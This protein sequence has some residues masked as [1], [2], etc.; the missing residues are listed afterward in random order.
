MKGKSKHLTEFRVR[1]Y[2]LDSYGHMNNAVY[3][4]YLEQARWEFT[5]DVS[6]LNDFSASDLFL[7]VVETH[8]RYL[9][10]AR[11]FDYLTV[12]TSCQVS[13][14]FLLFHQKIHNRT[15]DKP[16]ARATVKTV[17][18]NRD[19]SPQDIPESILKKI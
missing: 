15:L 16:A 1:G 2:E 9:Q 7:V 11:L 3:L 8:I 6:I 10:E 12:E 17:F 19:R 18:I 5:R 13:S 14:P 4:Q